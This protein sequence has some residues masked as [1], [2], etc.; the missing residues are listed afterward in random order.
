MPHS[1][2][3]TIPKRLEIFITQLLSNTLKR[4]TIVRKHVAFNL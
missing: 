1:G 3:N 2:V 4:R